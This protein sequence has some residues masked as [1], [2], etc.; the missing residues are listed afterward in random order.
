MAV[1]RSRNCTQHKTWGTRHFCDVE[2]LLCTDYVHDIF[3][4][5]FVANSVNVLNHTECK[6]FDTWHSNSFQILNIWWLYVINMSMVNFVP[7]RQT[8]WIIMRT[9]NLYWNINTLTFTFNYWIKVPVICLFLSYYG[10][11][12]SMIAHNTIQRKNYKYIV[13]GPELGHT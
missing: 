6:H 2:I 7:I 8:L 9:S 13:C 4:E 10:N 1:S 5:I 11:S 12:K 3:R